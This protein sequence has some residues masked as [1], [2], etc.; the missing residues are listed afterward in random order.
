MKGCCR[1][2]TSGPKSAFRHDMDSEVSVPRE[3]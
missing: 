2:G 1:A 3:A